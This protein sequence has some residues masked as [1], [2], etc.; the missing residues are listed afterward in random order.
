MLIE[1]RN[2][3]FAK[4]GVSADGSPISPDQAKKNLMHN[5]RKIYL[6]LM[7]AKEADMI[8]PEDELTQAQ[9]VLK[10]HL[11]ETILYYADLDRKSDGNIV[12]G[13]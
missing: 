10:D 4:Q 1:L 13:W 12:H 11:E 2:I 9:Q 3:K 6:L 7:E 5:T 8:I